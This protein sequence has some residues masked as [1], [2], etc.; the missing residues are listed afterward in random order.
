MDIVGLLLVVDRERDDGSTLA[1]SLLAP[2]SPFARK[3][4]S[5]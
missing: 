5:C 4:S 2:G 3:V 1:L